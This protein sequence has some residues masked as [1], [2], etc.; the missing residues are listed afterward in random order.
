MIYPVSLSLYSRAGIQTQTCL[1]LSVFMPNSMSFLHHQLTLAE[2]ID[3]S[4]L[5]FH[6]L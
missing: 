4:A 5:D 3:L 2:F 1:F 6:Y